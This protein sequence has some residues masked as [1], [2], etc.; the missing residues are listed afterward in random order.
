MIRPN[1]FPTNWHTMRVQIYDCDGNYICSGTVDR[2]G[3]LERLEM[4]TAE[5]MTE[6]I[7]F[8]EERL[9]SSYQPQF[10]G[11]PPETA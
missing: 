5:E 10:S 8:C 9:S 1:G 4:P 3:R 6:L 11:R 2:D 7:S